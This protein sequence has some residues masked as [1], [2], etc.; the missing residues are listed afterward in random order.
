MDGSKMDDWQISESDRSINGWIKDGPKWM[1]DR[2]LMDSWGG[3]WLD[4]WMI[5]GYLHGWMNEY[6]MD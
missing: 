6:W 2:F 4:G 5:N 3:C 1:I